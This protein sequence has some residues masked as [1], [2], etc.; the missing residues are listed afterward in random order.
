MRTMPLVAALGALAAWVPVAVSQEPPP[1]PPG[2]AALGEIE[3][4]PAASSLLVTL[5]CPPNGN[6]CQGDIVA[7]TTTKLRRPDGRSRTVRIGEA[8]FAPPTGESE[9]VRLRLP[10]AA[11]DRLRCR[12]RL[13][14]S[15]TK[16]VPA[17]AAAPAETRAVTVRTRKRP[18]SCP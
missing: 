13:G 15:V 4:S 8:P 14:V 18:R 10:R 11:R 6:D 9:T 17:E 1:P 3:A 12:G 5:V 2:V 7:R 16:T